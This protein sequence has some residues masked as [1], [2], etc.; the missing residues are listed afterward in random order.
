M[1][2]LSRGLSPRTACLAPCRSVWP[3]C[4][5]GTSPACP[6]SHAH[7]HADTVFARSCWFTNVHSCVSD[8][9]WERLR[10]M[11]A[12]RAGQR[13][14]IC[15][16]GPDSKPVSRRLDVHERWAYDE[17]RGTQVLRRLICLCDAC[18][19]TTHLGFANTKGRAAEALV[20]L[21]EVTGM[22]DA[23]VEVH[24]ESA[25]AVW[26]R[27]SARDWELDLRMLTDVGVTVIRPGDPA[28]RRSEADREL[29]RVHTT[30]PPPPVTP[31][32]R[33][34]LAA[35]AVS[36]PAPV[37]DTDLASTLRDRGQP[38]GRPASHGRGPRCR[39]VVGVGADGEVTVAGLLAELTEPSRWD[40]MRGRRPR[41]RVLQSVPF[42]NRNGDIRSDIDHV[43]IGPPGVVTIN[44]KHHQAGRVA[45]DGDE[46][47]VNRHRTDYLTKARRE[48]ERVAGLLEAALATAGYSGL[49]QRVPVRPMIVVVG[50]RLLVSDWAAGVSVVMPRQLLHTLT[51]MPGGWPPPMSRLCSVSPAAAG[52]G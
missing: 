7:D 38:R 10:R 21:C 33:V 30:T 11:V 31:L 25:N 36:T 49:A 22:S 29:R 45:L 6:P 18:H 32:R 47:T 28:Q 40:R 37:V 42:L 5:A 48:A 19:L 44:T 26:I 43:L 50:A 46:L 1:L 2:G 15:G 12:R 27:R 17:A 35:E 24:V 4:A 16:A 52:H 41:W 9:D 8:Q 13:C 34:P 20:H 14:E 23:E 3:R 51:S 39:S